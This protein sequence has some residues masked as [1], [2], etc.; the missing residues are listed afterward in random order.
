MS[1]VMT[2]PCRRGGWVWASWL[3]VLCLPACAEQGFECGREVPGQAGVFRRCDRAGEVCICA[4]NSCARRVARSA[5][6]AGAEDAGQTRA[7]SREPGI[8]EAEVEECPSGLLYVAAPFARPDLADKCVP[9]EH[10]QLSTPAGV[11]S[12]AEGELICPGSPVTEVAED[13]DEPE[14]RDAAP[15]SPGPGQPDG[16]PDAGAEDGAVDAASPAE[17]GEDPGD[18]SLP[19]AGTE[20]DAS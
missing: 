9:E 1:S 4:T 5:G 6:D 16:A 18:A 10:R 11:L 2:S 13:T 17:P 3:A 19:E 12:F 8:P 7:N 14:Q 20:G 15:P